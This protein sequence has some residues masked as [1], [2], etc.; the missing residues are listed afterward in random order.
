M[1]KILSILI[2]LFFLGCD[3]TLFHDEPFLIL[4]KPGISTRQ[5]YRFIYQI[6]YLRIDGDGDKLYETAY[7]YSN[8]TLKIGTILYLKAEK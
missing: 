5:G 6:R 3:D 7:I 2:I 1:K 8:D 4:S